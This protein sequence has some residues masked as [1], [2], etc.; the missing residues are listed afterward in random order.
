MLNAVDTRT[1]WNGVWAT[2]GD[3]SVILVDDD[4]GDDDLSLHIVDDRRLLQAAAD[5][6]ARFDVAD[7]K[8]KEEVAEPERQANVEAPDDQE[9]GLVEVGGPSKKLC[10]LMH[11]LQ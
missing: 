4:K 9:L 3:T 6:V 5:F 7:E 10:V 1:G 11:A 8:P 2:V